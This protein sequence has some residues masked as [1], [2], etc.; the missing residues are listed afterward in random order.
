MKNNKKSTRHNVFETNSS[1]SHSLSISLNGTLSDKLTPL[2]H[3]EDVDGNIYKNCIV[4][5]GAEFGWGPED[6]YDAH[7][8]AHYVATYLKLYGGDTKQKTL[9]ES[10]L[11]NHTGCDVVVYDFDQDTWSNDKKY[12]NKWSYIDHECTGV[13]AAALKN[14]ITLEHFIFDKKSILHIDNDN[15]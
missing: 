3:Y 8:K 2:D 7:T 14:E 11:K 6:H 1:S 13:P 10:V 9:F 15:H 4:F 5:N 12:E